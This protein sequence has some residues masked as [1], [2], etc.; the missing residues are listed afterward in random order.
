MSTYYIGCDT[1]PVQSNNGARLQCNY[2]NGAVS[3][4]EQEVSDLYA[5]ALSAEDGALFAGVI[6]MTSMLSWGGRLCLKS[7]NI[8]V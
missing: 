1:P 8:G 4:T 2:S 5:P 7:F 6:F 3:Y